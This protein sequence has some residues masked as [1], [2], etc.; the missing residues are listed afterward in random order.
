MNTWPW[1][2]QQWRTSRTVMSLLY[3]AAVV[4][5]LTEGQWWLAAAGAVFGGA[6][7]VAAT[8]AIHAAELVER[9]KA[10]QC[11]GGEPS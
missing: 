9:L 3:A 4:A 6:Y 7:A 5:L 11:E 8:R 2:S 1:T 10:E